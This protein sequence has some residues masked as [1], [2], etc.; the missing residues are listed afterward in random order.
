MAW[1]RHDDRRPFTA[2]MAALSDAAYRLDDE[3]L[4]WCA[5]NGTDGRVSARLMPTISPRSA[6]RRVVEE[7]VANGR[8][9]R[10][11]EVHCG[12]PRCPTPGL[13]GYSVH[14]YLQY[15]PTAAEAISEREATAQRVAK[16]RA[17]RN[18]SGNALQEPSQT[19]YEQ[20]E[21]RVTE[22]VSNAFPRVDPDPDPEVVVLEG[23]LTLSTGP[24][25]PP[26][27]TCSDHPKGTTEPCGPCG[28]ARRH[29]AAWQVAD[30]ADQRKRDAERRSAQARARAETAQHAIAACRLCD[31]RGYANGTVCDHDPST[32]HRARRGAAAARQA[33]NTRSA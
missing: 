5:A 13:D 1:T 28:E 29:H 17:S 11:G 2:K 4:S 18:G 9:H 22:R 19:E 30:A 21:E 8:L 27:S 25:N 33:L 20:D 31:D 14:D 10:A 7:L 12:H 6:R 32:P 23:D 3:L 26:F 15:N 16:W 24:G